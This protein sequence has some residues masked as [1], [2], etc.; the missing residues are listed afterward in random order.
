MKKVV[1]LVSMYF[2]LS[3]QNDSSF[4]EKHFNIALRN[5]GHE[6]LLKSGDSSSAVLPIKKIAQNL[7]QIEFQSELVFAHDTLVELFRKN[8]KISQL[9]SNYIV[10]V[11]N[12]GTNKIVFGYEIN[13]KTKNTI[14]C[15][16]RKQAKGCYVIQIE[17]LEEK[18]NF[19]PYLWLLILPIIALYFFRNQILGIRKIEI[20][21]KNDDFEKIGIFEYLP[22]KSALKSPTEIIELTE[23]E[24]KLLQILW[25]NQNQLIHREQLLKEIWEDQGSIVVSRSLDVLVSKL[26]KKIK[27]DPSIKISNIHGKGYKIA[28]EAV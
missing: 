20:I 24:N 12:C 3:C 8:L 1:F 18:P 9:P 2:L 27:D 14:P 22:E 17:F 11:L 13:L 4:Q 23:N 6:L 5:I 16:G 7:H 10:S 26:R 15:T 21:D 19:L 25:K 28:R